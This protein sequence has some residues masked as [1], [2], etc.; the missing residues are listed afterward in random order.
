M[1]MLEFIILQTTAPAAVASK[2]AETFEK[3]DPWGFAMAFI[4]MS[5][6]FVS[7]ILLYVFF[8]N[9]G[10]MFTKDWKR[11]ALLKAG[12]VEEAQHIEVST[13][14]ELNAAIAY[15]LYLYR[16]E[17]H[18][19]ESFKITANKVSRNYS[20]WSSKIYGI[21]QNQNRNW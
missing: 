16:N 17:M 2:S 15:A 11:R 4:A 21:H 19:F 20:P 8:K 6:V 3:L 13:T 5:V 9:I 18:D 12:K 10:Y 1:I 14:G 7:L